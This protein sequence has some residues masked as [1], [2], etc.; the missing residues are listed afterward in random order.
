MSTEAAEL[1]DE[2][3]RQRFVFIDALRGIAAVMVC[4]DHLLGNTV[5][6][7][8]LRQTFPSAVCKACDFGARGVQIFFVIS[9]FVIAH[10]LRAVVP[11]LGA[12]GKFILRRQ[13]RLDPPYWVV[14]GLTLLDMA[15]ENHIPSFARKPQP[16]AAAV[17]SNLFYLQIFLRSQVIVAV[18]WTLCM[19]I[20]FY[21]C[22][23]IIAMI[24]R[25][26]P[27]REGK[28][29]P[30]MLA[31]VCLLCILS[32]VQT[33]RQATS[34]PLFVANWIY[35]AVG[36]LC[37][38]QYTNR[39]PKAAFVAIWVTVGLTAI[40]FRSSRMGVGFATA[41]LLYIAAERHRLATW[42]SFNAIQYFGRLS[43]SLYLTH[44]LVLDVIMRGGYKLTHTNRPAAVLW[45]L[46][47]ALAAL[48]VAHYFHKWIEAPSMRMAT[49]FRSMNRALEVQPAPDGPASPVIAIAAE[50]TT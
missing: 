6:S 37:Y 19:E 18:S 16:N 21:F 32:V 12:A 29:A 50:A 11:T 7:P 36:A 48:C 35:F 15:I 42:L 38:W 45:F 47:A 13:L 33:D 26:T 5:L 44:V 3:G 46:V 41:S 40:W 22:F 34:Q 1:A 9:G 4:F 43:Y 28:I 8:I 24:G 17:I 23:V 49:R 30:G 39:A 2:S 14:I 25:I 31:V 10:S 27:A 20:Q